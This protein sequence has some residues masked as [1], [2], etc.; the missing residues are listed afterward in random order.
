MVYVHGGG[1][2]IDSAVKY[3][4]RE[5]FS[6][7]YFK[8]MNLFLLLPFKLCLREK[9]LCC[10]GVVVVTIQYR[11]GLLGF[12]SSGDEVCAGNLGLWDMT[13]A[14][15][16]VQDNIKAFGGD[17]NRVT[18]VGQSAGGASVDMLAISPHSRG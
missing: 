5:E 11:L 12:F 3:G 1:F 6:P 2:L 15:R 14:L 13:M 4:D 8:D 16:W 9:Y 18:V 17:P 7:E 10:H